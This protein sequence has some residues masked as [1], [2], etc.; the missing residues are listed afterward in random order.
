MPGQ[1]FEAPT[2]WATV[3][4]KTT[5]AAE[6]QAK[7]ALTAAYQES[8]Y[9]DLGPHNWVGIYGEWLIGDETTVEMRVQVSY[10]DTNWYTAHIL[11]TP[12]AGVSAAVA[13]VAQFT[14]ANYTTTAFVYFDVR[15]RSAM[16]ARVQYK[17][18]GGTPTGSMTLRM[19]AGA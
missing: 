8:R 9:G 11:E 16:F 1:A 13:H 5:G 19:C 7:D 6:I 12:T 2:E 10:D 14:A 15:V 17:A 3:F 18:T 4:Y